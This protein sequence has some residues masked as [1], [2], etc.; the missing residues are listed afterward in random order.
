MTIGPVC[1]N[2]FLLV[3]LH[4]RLRT[5]LG[6]PN[7]A[8]ESLLCTALYT[9]I[10]RKMSSAQAFV[11]ASGSARSAL[12]CNFDSA[13]AQTCPSLLWGLKSLQG[14]QTAVRLE[15]L[16]VTNLADFASAV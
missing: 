11:S 14:S 2:S 10:S 9:G 3:R 1:D 16:D 7:A 13:V 15:L 4:G 12:R 8:I 5:N 6:K